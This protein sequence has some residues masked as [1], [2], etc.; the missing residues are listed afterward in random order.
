MFDMTKMVKRAC[1]YRFYPEQ[2]AKLSRTFGCV[3]KVYNLALQ[4]RMTAWNFRAGRSQ[5]NVSSYFLS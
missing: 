5:R 3:R 2:S 4:A 1:K